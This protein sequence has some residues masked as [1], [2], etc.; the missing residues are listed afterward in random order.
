MS[1]LIESRSADAASSLELGDESKFC[2]GGESD[3]GDETGGELL[4]AVI[5]SFSTILAIEPINVTFANVGL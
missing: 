2:G 4:R 3:T 1:A 5:L